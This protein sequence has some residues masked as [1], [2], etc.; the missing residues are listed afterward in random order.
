MRFLRD[1]LPNSPVWILFPDGA[2]Y[3]VVLLI[4]LG[5]QVGD[6]LVRFGA[7]DASNHRSVPLKMFSNVVFVSDTVLSSGMQAVAE[8]LRSSVGHTVNVQVVRAG[9]VVSLTL[10]PRTWSGRGLLGCHLAPV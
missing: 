9:Q 6:R 4:A 7:V 2:V 1:L 5:L 3:H 8:E 10:A